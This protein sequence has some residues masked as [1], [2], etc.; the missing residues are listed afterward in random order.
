[1]T[2]SN[3]DPEDLAL[4][5]EFCIASKVSGAI[6]GKSGSAE[7]FLEYNSDGSVGRIDELMDDFH[8]LALVNMKGKVIDFRT[9]MVQS[10]KLDSVYELDA[11]EVLYILGGKTDIKLDK[12][13][14]QLTKLR[15]VIL[16]SYEGT[17]LPKELIFLPSLEELNIS[18]TF[19]VK[20]T[21][22][23]KEIYTQGLEAIR[24]YYTSLEET[25][26]TEYLCEA[27][28]VLVGRGAVGKTSLVNTLTIPN[29]KLEEEQQ[30]TEGIEIKYWDLDMPE[31]KR[32]RFRYNIWDFGGQE[33][34]DATHQ[35]FITERSLYL[36]V[37]EAR[38][39]SNFLDF[40][41]WLNVVNLF[42]G[43]S[44]VIVVKN[45][46]D[47]RNKQLPTKRYKERFENIFEFVDVSC[48]AGHEEKIE[49]LIEE[50][51]KATL[52]LPQIRDELPKVWVDIRADL[53]KL[54]EEGRDW[55]TYDEYLKVCDERGMDKTK[56]DFLSQY[57]HDLGVVVHHQKHDLLKRKVILN[58]DWA[59]DGVY[60]VLDNEEIEAKNG[61][62]T[63]KDL[64]GIWNEA[65]YKDM[66]PELLALMENYEICFEIGRQTYIAPELLS[67]D[68]PEFKQLDDP[69]PLTFIYKFTFMP[70]G[71][72]T[73]FIVKANRLIEGTS[74]WRSGVVI[75]EDGARAVLVEDDTDRSITVHIE[76]RH[77]RRELLA[78][79]R[80]KFSEIF[81]DFNRKI[82]FQELT[83]CTCQHCLTSETKHYFSWNKLLKY[84]RRG[85]ETIDCQES[86]TLE[87]VNVEKLVSNVAL[88]IWAE[89]GELGFDIE[90]TTAEPSRLPAKKDEEYVVHI[91][92]GA[93]LKKAKRDVSIAICTGA[94]SVIATLIILIVMLTWN[95]ME[96]ITWIATISISIAA[97]LYGAISTKEFSPRGIVNELTERRA[98]QIE[99][100]LGV[101]EEEVA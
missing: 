40:D 33:K 69:N 38:K 15:R 51:K 64:Q 39:E 42:G 81:E 68:P 50:I 80:D 62:F 86:P 45:K 2:F 22:P 72:M 48:A 44:P 27:K 70:A 59:V 71:I 20:L 98:R 53:K 87:K 32:G 63:N 61:R 91:E 65:R 18:D 16:E 28:M 43:N 74:Y 54:K 99:E 97:Y 76:G 89:A 75:K 1:M 24:N 78:V 88:N 55:I 85:R 66:H 21:T 73:R 10:V 11:L 67:A 60:N 12:R 41:Y 30:S 93:I 5:V 37:T 95:V 35:F 92:R 26:E 101:L 90:T 4:L 34:Y 96:P 94:S 57:F 46:V 17:T 77:G 3:I 19:R 83:P 36:F 58:P 7:L 100:S 79:I 84:H 23:P 13:V 29:Y 25:T 14:Q 82:D 56:A 9:A 52:T 6:R 47:E 49:A 31:T 8:W